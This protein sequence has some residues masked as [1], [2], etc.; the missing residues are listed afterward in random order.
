MRVDASQR[1][2]RVE[3]ETEAAAVLQ[4]QHVVRENH[5]RHVRQLQLALKPAQ[6][7]QSQ[8]KAQHLGSGKAAK[9]VKKS[10]K[11]GRAGKDQSSYL[12]RSGPFDLRIWLSV[13]VS[14]HGPNSN[15][16]VRG[17]ALPGCAIVSE[18]RTFCGQEQ[19]QETL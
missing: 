19:F 5:L 17:S 16:D 14:V 8:L 11:S 9:T 7:D 6:I 18:I 2:Q 4:P 13:A 10:Q 1:V 12:S 15:C 3:L